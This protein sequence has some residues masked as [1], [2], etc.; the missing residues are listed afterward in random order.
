M[1]DLDTPI[2]PQMDEEG[3]AS[4]ML[5]MGLG[6]RPWHG[7]LDV[8]D[9]A[10]PSIVGQHN[11]HAYALTV[12]FVGR[13]DPDV[14]RIDDDMNVQIAKLALAI[15]RRAI[16]ERKTHQPDTEAAARRERVAVYCGLP[17]LAGH[18]VGRAQSALAHEDA[19]LE[20]RIQNLVST[21][22]PKAGQV[23]APPAGMHSAL[24]LHR[25]LR[26]FGDSGVPY[27]EELV[28]L[29]RAS[30]S[31]FGPSMRELLRRVV[32]SGRPLLQSQ[33]GNALHTA[34]TGLIAEH[35]GRG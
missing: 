19:L 6:P 13:R 32:Y 33:F 20:E 29:G 10:A 22:W 2:P 5:T 12:L 16:A 18:V 1:H 35:T 30:G 9:W 24:A 25:H 23:K 27:L 4:W 3:W 28:K 17:L 14:M 31:T 21:M 34:L 11:A 8:P 15:G 26:S 7:A